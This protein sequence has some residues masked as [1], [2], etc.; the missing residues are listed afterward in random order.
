[1]NRKERIAF[2]TSLADKCDR[3]GLH[4]LASEVDAQLKE[5][6][7]GI[8]SILSIYR[9][10]H[11]ALAS[12]EPERVLTA[13]IRKDNRDG[14]PACPF[15]LSIPQG[16]KFVG[17]AVLEMSSRPVD[18]KHNRR[19]YNKKRTHCECPYA[20]QIVESENSVQCSFGTINSKLPHW[21]QF[22][23]SPYYPKLWQGFNL[24]DIQMDRNYYTY[25]DYGYYSLY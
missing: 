12:G 21:K 3:L 6:V 5:E 4:S 17:E 22:R 18:H 9:D 14:T 10:I 2:L 20:L 11:K 19:I 7:A 13:A 23:S 16:C 1:M 15:G 24:T 8:E 25:N